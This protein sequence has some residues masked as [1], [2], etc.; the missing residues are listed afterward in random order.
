[1]LRE[2]SEQIQTIV[3]DRD[4]FSRGSVRPSDQ[5]GRYD[6]ENSDLRGA[7]MSSRLTENA[8][9]QM[10][11]TQGDQ[12]LTYLGWY[13]SHMWYRFMRLYS[14]RAAA[15]ANRGKALCGSMTTSPWRSR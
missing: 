13:M 12:T 1:M 9:C 3:N 11:S 6:V 10:L 2:V 7:R 8:T 15:R 5:V 4:S 14:A